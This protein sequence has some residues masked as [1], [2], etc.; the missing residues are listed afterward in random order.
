METITIKNENTGI[1]QFNDKI[2]QF[3][4]LYLNF[5]N[6]LELLQN[7]ISKGDDCNSKYTELRKALKEQSVFNSLDIF[8]EV[9]HI[10]NEK[11]NYAKKWIEISTRFNQIFEEPLEYPV[12]IMS[13]ENKDV[14]I[15]VLNNEKGFIVAERDN[16][17][18]SHFIPFGNA[19]VKDL[20]GNSIDPVLA[21]FYLANAFINI[22]PFLIQKTYKLSKEFIE[23]S[24]KFIIQLQCYG[25]IINSIKKFLLDS[26]YYLNTISN[27]EMLYEH[28]NTNIKPFLDNILQCEKNIENLETNIRNVVN[29]LKIFETMNNDQD[30]MTFFS[31]FVINSKNLNNI[32]NQIDINNL[33]IEYQHIP[34]EIAYEDIDKYAQD[35][36]E[37]LNNQTKLKVNFEK[38]IQI[39]KNLHNDI[40]FKGQAIFCQDINSQDEDEDDFPQTIKLNIILKEPQKT[41]NFSISKEL[42]LTILLHEYGHFF[43]YQHKL[44]FM[45]FYVES[46]YKFCVC[47]ITTLLSDVF[48]DMKKYLKN[49]DITNIRQN[50]TDLNITITRKIE[51]LQ[52]QLSSKQLQFSSQDNMQN[53]DTQD[54]LQKYISKIQK[55]ANYNNERLADYFA[56]KLI[57]DKFLVGILQLYS[58]DME[59]IE[60]PYIYDKTKMRKIINQP[61]YKEYDLNSDHLALFERVKIKKVLVENKQIKN[62]K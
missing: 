28:F 44:N 18:N 17:N 30:V 58:N 20:A 11:F 54:P 34:D 56:Y 50:L 32:E 13:T 48:T 41:N 9:K 49:I 27:D 42:F 60:Q 45:R 53:L 12:H 29:I 35:I 10:L 37:Q 2:Q 8:T 39:D 6:I 36:I 61:N 31:G 40:M 14:Y 62:Q 46:I 59:Q 5:S 55:L 57:Q 33:K 19:D 7:D 22:N 51:Q 16:Y 4:Q 23:L 15:T 3:L 25:Y 43:Y 24:D 1:M 47:D 26:F 52:S 38:E 21:D